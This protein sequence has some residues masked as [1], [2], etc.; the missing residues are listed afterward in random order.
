[1]IIAVII[2]SNISLGIN[3]TSGTDGT[4][5]LEKVLSNTL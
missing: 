5:N 4:G 3:V 1:M 2:E